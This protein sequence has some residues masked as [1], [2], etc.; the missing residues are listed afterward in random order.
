[1]IKQLSKLEPK[2]TKDINN[3]RKKSHLRKFTKQELMDFVKKHKIK[4]N[5]KKVKQILIDAIWDW[6]S[7]DDSDSDSDSDSSS[8]SDSDSS[9]SDSDSD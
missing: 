5:E 4:V 6:L 7:K 1:V 3:V 8:D 9:D 2:D